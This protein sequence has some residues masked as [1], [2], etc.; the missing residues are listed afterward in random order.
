MRGSSRSMEVCGGRKLDLTKD[1][2]IQNTVVVYS[3]IVTRSAG[4]LVPMIPLV[5]LL[6]MKLGMTL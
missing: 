6:H 4:Q 5:R 3:V 1:G 2:Q